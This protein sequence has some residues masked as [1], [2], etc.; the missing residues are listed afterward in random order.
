[1]TC[2]VCQRAFVPTGRQKFCS[3]ACRAA[4]YRRRRD[5]GQVVAELPAARPRRPHTVYECDGCG[6]RAVGA[7]YCEECRTFM[8]RVGRGGLCPE[9]DAAV[10]VAELLDEEVGPG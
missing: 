8:R 9:C 3:G 4:A 6:E 5:A 2:P 7:Q 1:M 10:T